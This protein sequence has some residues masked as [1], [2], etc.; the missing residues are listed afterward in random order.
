MNLQNLFKTLKSIS[1]KRLTKIQPPSVAS[2]TPTDNLKNVLEQVAAKTDN[3][4]SLE[5]VLKKYSKL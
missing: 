5:D 4:I 1:A 3:V 2:F